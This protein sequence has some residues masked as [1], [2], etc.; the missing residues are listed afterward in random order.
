MASFTQSMDGGGTAATSRSSGMSATGQGLVGAGLVL[1][2]YGL[3]EANHKQAE[4]ERANASYYREQAAYA[5]SAGE[6]ARLIH[7]KESKILFGNQVS[8]FAKAGLDTSDSSLFLASQKLYAFQEDAAI[9]KETAMQVHL[10]NLRADQSEQ[11]A[12]DLENPLNTLLQLAPAGL[13]AA[14]LFV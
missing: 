9:A 12:S 1:R 6:R 2:A 10:A 13:D 4:S 14:A 5:E 7:D 11:T 8:A 3:F